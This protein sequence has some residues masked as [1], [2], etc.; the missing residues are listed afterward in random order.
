[1]LRLALLRHRGLPVT[2]PDLSV[3][4]ERQKM[5]DWLNHLRGLELTSTSDLNRADTRIKIDRVIEW[6]LKWPP[7]NDFMNRAAGGWM[8]DHNFDELARAIL[9]VNWEKMGQ[10]TGDTRNIDGHN[11]EGG[12]L[13]S[14]YRLDLYFLQRPI[15]V[16]IGWAPLH[17]FLMQPME[18]D[19]GARLDEALTASGTQL[20]HSSR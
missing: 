13:Y 15:L 18:G 19:G 10:I 7:S 8:A 12:L 16:Q 14:L 11:L 4:A 1:M 17:F 2:D 6:V 5:V 3:Q 20:T 9:L